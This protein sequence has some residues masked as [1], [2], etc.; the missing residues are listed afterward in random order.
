MNIVTVKVGTKYSSDDV[1][2]LFDSI[3]TDNFYCITDDSTGLYPEIKV[4]EPEEGLDGVWNK[5]ALFKH[6]LGK[7]MYLDLDVV[8]QGSIR[9]IYNVSTFTMVKCFWKPLDQ[10]HDGWLNNMDHNINSS[11]MVWKGLECID[12]WNKFIEDPEYYMT[13]YHGIDHFIYHEGFKSDFWKQGK[14]YSRLFGIN[15]D[16]WYNPQKE[17]FLPAASICLMNGPTTKKDYNRLQNDINK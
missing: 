12:I 1:N 2:I 10:L 3:Y 6:D 5:M 14:I 9:S 17:Y 11:V 7:V 4:I 15:A 16:S 8:I 13:K